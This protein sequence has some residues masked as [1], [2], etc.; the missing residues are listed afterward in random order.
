MIVFADAAS[1][2]WT[3][4]AHQGPYV[5]LFAVL[6]IAGYKRTWV[7]ASQADRETKLKDDLAASLK[8]SFGETVKLKDA[9]IAR[10]EDELRREREEKELYRQY[11]FRLLE[12]ARAATNVAT[13]AVAKRGNP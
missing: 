9:Q 2:A 12:A 13:D 10:V 11:T 7:F 4:I 5:V 3:A 8:E 1:D 6:L